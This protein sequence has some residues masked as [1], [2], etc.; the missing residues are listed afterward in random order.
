MAHRETDN[1]LPWWQRSICIAASVLVFALT[2]AVLCAVVAA[3]RFPFFNPFDVTDDVLKILISGLATVI[4][5][6]VVGG[7][8]MFTTYSITKKIEEMKLEA[9]RAMEDERMAFQKESELQKQRMEIYKV[10]YL[11]RVAAVKDIT[12]LGE[13]TN[14]SLY[15]E[16]L[17]SFS[18][19]DELNE[20]TKVALKR[21]AEKV[22]ENCESFVRLRIK[23]WWILTPDLHKAMTEVIESISKYAIA[24]FASSQLKNGKDIDPKEINRLASDVT[25]KIVDMSEAVS[26]MM[27]KGD[28]K[29]MI[30]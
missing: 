8:A 20:L 6:C 3:L 14:G 17:G 1:K 21:N 24:C 16:I 4:G 11:E 30:G 26:E 23:Y 29:N 18:T 10:L 12:S 5:A 15:L 9:Q 7:C 25:M 19:S 28:L 13:V 27:H 22:S 2:L